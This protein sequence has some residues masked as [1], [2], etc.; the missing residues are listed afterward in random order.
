M[1]QRRGGKRLVACFIFDFI[2]RHFHRVVGAG[3]HGNEAELGCPN[4][5]TGEP[6]H[7]RM[8]I[9]CFGQIRGHSI[10]SVRCTG[11]CILSVRDHRGFCLRQNGRWLW[12]CNVRFGRRICH[13]RVLSNAAWFSKYFGCFPGE[14]CPVRS[15]PMIASPR[16]STSTPFRSSLNLHFLTVLWVNTSNSICMTFCQSGWLDCSVSAVW[17]V[18]LVICWIVWVKLIDQSSCWCWHSQWLMSGYRD[19]F[20]W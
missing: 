19:K 3:N 13:V 11:F 9:W 12:F 16:Q 15:A 18:L 20:C 1:K 8:F 4:R 14:I 10:W 7:E 6:C 2:G 5:W 17:N